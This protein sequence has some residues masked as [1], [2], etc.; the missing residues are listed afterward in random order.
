MAKWLVKERVDLIKNF[1]SVSS[2]SSGGGAG[3]K[4]QRERLPF[5]LEAQASALQR[6]A[7]TRVE[8][9][10]LVCERAERVLDEVVQ[11]RRHG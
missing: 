6:R 9:R 2:N 1:P 5:A 10:S 3:P 8:G 11:V 4:V 7:E